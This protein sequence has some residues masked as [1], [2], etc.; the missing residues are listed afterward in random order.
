MTR[1]HT[2]GLP[3]DR[4][5]PYKNS[6]HQSVSKDIHGR[7]WTTLWANTTDFRRLK[8]SGALW[9]WCPVPVFESV[10]VM[11]AVMC[12]YGFCPRVA[13]GLARGSTARGP[14]GRGGSSFL[15][16]SGPGARSGEAGGEH[17]D[18]GFACKG[19]LGRAG[20][21]ELRARFLRSLRVALPP[22]DIEDVQC[23]PGDGVGCGGERVQR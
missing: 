9:S 18:L 23:G 7:S 17:G 2:V 1:Q 15:V 12:G 10:F 5:K 8:Y 13:A 14:G 4:P 19:L 16:G 21:R 20:M 3:G 6:Q 22:G 11:T